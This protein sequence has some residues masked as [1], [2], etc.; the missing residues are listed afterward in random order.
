[1]ADAVRI[2][3]EALQLE[4]QQRARLAHE[5]I[6]SLDDDDPAAAELWREEIER[7][8][9]EVEAGAVGLEDWSAV[10]ARVRARFPV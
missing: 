10:R 7:R 5:M 8:I 6:R 2:L 4:P 3:E 1:M 9:D